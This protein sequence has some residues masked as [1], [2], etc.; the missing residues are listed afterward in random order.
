MKGR[1]FSPGVSCLCCLGGNCYLIGHVFVG[2]ECCCLK[3]EL[4]GEVDKEILD[5]WR[6]FKQKYIRTEQEFQISRAR[7]GKEV[8]RGREAFTVRHQDDREEREEATGFRCRRFINDGRS[9]CRVVY[10]ECGEIS[11]EWCPIDKRFG[12][13]FVSNEIQLRYVREFFE[14]VIE[15]PNIIQRQNQILGSD[16]HDLDQKISDGYAVEVPVI[17]GWKKGEVIPSGSTVPPGPE[18]SWFGS[19]YHDPFPTTRRV[20]RRLWDTSFTVGKEQLD[21]IQQVGITL[22]QSSDNSCILTSEERLSAARLLWIWRDIFVDR[23]EDLAM[24]DLVVHT[25]P[26]LPHSKPHRAKDLIYAEDEVRWQTTVLPDMIGNIIQGGTSPWVAKTTWVSK[27]DTVV[28]PVCGRWPLRMVHTYCQL[29]DATIKTNYPMKRMEPILNELANPRHRYFFSVDAA[30][31]FYAVPIYPPHAYKTAFN[32]LLGQFYYLRMPMGL[33]GAPATYARLKDITFGPIPAP[34][35]EPAVIA[36]LLSSRSPVTFKYFCDDD[37]GAA[38]TFQQ[39]LSFLHDIYFPRIHWARLTLKP[40]KSRFFVPT[41]EPLGMTVGRHQISEQEFRYGLKASDAKRGKIE[42]FPTPQNEQ[43][44]DAFLHL[45]TYLKILIPDRTQ[46]AKT[47]RESVIREKTKG[48]R[49]KA[50]GFDWTERQQE[51]LDLIK[52]SVRDNVVVGGDVSRRFYISVTTTESGFGAVLFQ[53]PEEIE[54]TISKN[55]HKYP[56]G[57]ERVVQFISQSFS[58][59]ETRYMGVERSYLAI[60][61]TLEEVR[62]LVLQSPF[63]IIVYTP[64]APLMRKIEEFK[65]R[66]ACWQVRMAEF[67]VEAYPI[68]IRDISGDVAR[69]MEGI[70]FEDN[71][72]EAVEITEIDTNLE[73]CGVDNVSI[74]RVFEGRFAELEYKPGVGLMID[75]KAILLYVDGACRGNGT[76]AARASIGIYAGPG[77]PDSKGIVISPTL[78]QGVLTNQVAELVALICGLDLGVSIASGHNLEKVVIASDSAY[79]CKGITRWIDRWRLKKYADVHNAH[80]FSH[81]DEKMVQAENRGVSVKIWKIERRDNLEADMLA[82]MVLNERG[83]STVVGVEGESSSGTELGSGP[84]IQQQKDKW[85]DW[86]SDPWYGGVVS[87]LLFGRTRGISDQRFRKICRESG[88]YTLVNMPEANDPPR[89]AYEEVNGTQAICIRQ[90]EVERILHRFHDNHGHFSAGIMGRNIMGRYYWPC[91]LQDIAKWCNSCPACQKLGPRRNCTQLKPIMS[92]QPMDL[93]GMDFVGPITPHSRNGSIY[94]LLVVDYFSR[95]LFAHATK[96]STGTAVVEFLKKISNTFGWPLAFYVDNGSHFV[97]GEVPMVLKSAGTKM[98]TAPITNPRSVGLAERYVQLIL[99]G[100]RIKIEAE[101]SLILGSTMD[102]WDEY[103]DEVVHSINSRV[104]K[105][106]GYTPSQLFLGFNVRLHPLDQ[107]L[108]EELRCTRIE[109][110]LDIFTQGTDLEDHERED[111]ERE[112]QTAKEYDLRLAQVEE[113][114]ELVR[115]RVLL[116]LD[117]K[118]IGITVPRYQSPKLGDLVLRRRFNVE[119]SLGMKLYTKWDGPYRLSKISKSGVSGYIEDLKTGRVL[120]RYAFGALKVFVPREMIVADGSWVSVEEGLRGEPLRERKEV[121]LLR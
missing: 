3:K 84:G 2:C 68:K 86:L 110:T 93:M 11:C 118:E 5:E 21:W 104:L 1:M 12:S 106:H 88:K 90:S 60:L 41:I 107:T 59:T 7:K 100:L 23:V 75:G 40:S 27:K 121:C 49:G 71:W 98:F 30:Y 16:V 120:G 101:S 92:L 58:D 87:Y 46:L 17:Q 102:K 25:I 83:I 24:T 44:I 39:L 36:E 33:T 29:N 48:K 57:E 38:P 56:R 64:I 67:H 55:G 15:P 32:T 69:I 45:T 91:R 108:V 82:R 72:G 112:A 9:R 119:K 14:S 47:L 31:G 116:D 8:V 70:Q 103:L 76:A 62:Y 105:V 52:K 74:N 13:S 94:I 63:P 42:G 111:H 78:Y 97:K 34:R 61:R 73:V 18:E 19:H 80:L 117:E 79:A 10:G 28:D 4:D 114:R 96:K 35:G 66:L 65:G 51:A 20:E 89:L 109:E 50:I 115:E 95:Y 26:T 99:A 22:G 43:Q 53:L 85:G 81:L 37:Y 6:L 54:Q 113:V 77:H